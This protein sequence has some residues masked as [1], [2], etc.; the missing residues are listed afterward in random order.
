M[1]SLIKRFG[2]NALA[3]ECEIQGWEIPTAEEVKHADI[4]HD[5]VWVRD[6]PE[7]EA[8]RET[9]GYVYYKSKD[10]MVLCNK[11]FMEN[12]VVIR[13]VDKDRLIEELVDKIDGQE[14]LINS[15][16]EKYGEM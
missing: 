11:S 6:I 15:Y 13:V 4:M 5:C 3:D 2:Y 8:D 9:H 7:D 16:I 14:Y 1:K 10:R 12:A